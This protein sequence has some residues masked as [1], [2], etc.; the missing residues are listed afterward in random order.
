MTQLLAE[1]RAQ[2]DPAAVIALYEEFC[3][4][5]AELKQIM[6]AWQLRGD[7]TAN[8]HRDADYDRAVLQ[9][10]ADLNARLGPLLKRLAPVSPRLA[11]YG[12]RLDRAAAR[13][14]AG[15]HSYVA[16]LIADS[17]HTV[18]FELHED[19]LSLAGLTRES[20]VPASR[21]QARNVGARPI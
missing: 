15:E 2:A 14:A 20:G 13:I 4:L 8:D 18:W 6:T 17:Y 12:A 3:V 9:R 16:R 21:P 11:G 1:E 5:D 10:L 7:S 19:L